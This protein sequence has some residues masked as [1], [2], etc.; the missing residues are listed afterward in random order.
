VIGGNLPRVCLSAQHRLGPGNGLGFDVEHFDR[1]GRLAE[2]REQAGQLLA[3]SPVDE[4]R[5]A[6]LDSAGG[7]LEGVPGV[8]VG[9]VVVPLGQELM[10]RRRRVP[11]SLVVRREV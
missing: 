4:E 1:P 11:K 5:G 3:E 8:A 10:Q 9:L 7:I 6:N 2:L